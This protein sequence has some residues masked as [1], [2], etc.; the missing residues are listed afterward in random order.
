MSLDIPV[1]EME[2][3][4]NKITSQLPGSSKNLR[5]STYSSTVLVFAVLITYVSEILDSKSIQKGTM[6]TVPLRHWAIG[7]FDHS[8]TSTSRITTAWRYW[9]VLTQ[10]TSL[11]WNFIYFSDWKSPTKRLGTCGQNKHELGIL[12]QSSSFRSMRHRNARLLRTA[13]MPKILPN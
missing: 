5:Y 4:N 9:I 12:S 8:R 11:L 7:Q 6:A 1:R 2:S 10:S 3:E 13:Y